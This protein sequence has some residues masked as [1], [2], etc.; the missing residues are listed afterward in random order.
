MTRAF[1]SSTYRDLKDHRAYVIDRLRR[2]GIIVD[3][4]EM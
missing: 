1:V 2:G 4:M 3:P